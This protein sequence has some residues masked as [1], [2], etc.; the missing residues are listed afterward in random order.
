MKYIFK[1][2]NIYNG[3]SISELRSLAYQ[4]AKSIGTKYP[5]S[6]ETNK[7]SSKDWYYAFMKR[8]RD[9]SLRTPEQLSQNR[10]KSFNKDDVAAFFDNLNKVTSENVFEPHRI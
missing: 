7:K 9:L 2:S 4:Y 1:A 6:W 10:A 3:L 8:H 5:D